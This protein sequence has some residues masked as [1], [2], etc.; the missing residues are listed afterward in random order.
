[1]GSY[2]I[3]WKKSALRELK[4]IDRQQI[5]RILEVIESLS[6]EPYPSQYRK[7]KGSEK[8]HRIKVGDYRV[9]YGVSTDDKVIRIYR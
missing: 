7:L 6:I 3:R 8:E 2:E 4:K 5:P 9:I 1:M